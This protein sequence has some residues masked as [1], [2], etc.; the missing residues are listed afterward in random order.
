MVLT[1]GHLWW[2]LTQCVP[3]RTVSP[4]SAFQLGHRTLTEQTCRYRQWSAP[5]GQSRRHLLSPLRL[6]AIISSGLPWQPS[7]CPSHYRTAFDYYAA[8][9]LRPAC[10]HFLTP[11]GST[12][13]GVPSFQLEV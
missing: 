10:W 12:G 3:R 13:I 8:S 5:A 9:V 7:P 2:Q 11:F 6:L 4:H 1:S